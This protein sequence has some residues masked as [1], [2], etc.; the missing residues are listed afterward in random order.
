MSL[1]RVL[2]FAIDSINSCTDEVHVLHYKMN[3]WRTANFAE[4]RRYDPLGLHWVSPDALTREIPGREFRRKYTPGVV[5]GGDWDLNTVDFSRKHFEAFQQRFVEGHPW[6]E[7]FLYQDALSRKPGDYYHGCRTE[8]EIEDRLRRYEAI[9]D[10][11]ARDGYLSQ[12]ELLARSR[13]AG[14]YHLRATPP[15]LN[16]VIVHI[17]RDGG[18]IF[19]DGRHRVS[20]AK[21]LRIR[22]IPVLVIVRHREWVARDEDVLR[23]QQTST[24]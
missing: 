17:G 8:S 16:E 1:K 6:K 24:H 13:A 22:M 4:A 18:Y 19:D 10:A 15:E 23:I 2:G 7:T 20:I 12:R 9:Y 3:I 5:V 11:M 14:S 21:I